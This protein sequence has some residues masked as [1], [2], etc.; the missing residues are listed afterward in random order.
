[1]GVEIAE[2]DPECWQELIEGAMPSIVEKISSNA[3]VGNKNIIATLN[4]SG[5]NVE[6]QFSE[7]ARATEKTGDRSFIRGKKWD[8][9]N[10]ILMIGTIM[11]SKFTFIICFFVS[12]TS[13][14]AK[15]DAIVLGCVDCYSSMSLLDSIFRELFPG[16]NPKWILYQSHEYIASNESNATTEIKKGACSRPFDTTLIELVYLGQAFGVFVL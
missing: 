11:K 9:Q 4:Q 16:R 5:M 2:N 15:A 12:F 10:E 7:Y 13:L 3:P 8:F 1:M 14:T 6:Q